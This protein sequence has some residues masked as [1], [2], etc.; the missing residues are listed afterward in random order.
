MGGQWWE[1]FDLTRNSAECSLQASD[2]RD[3]LVWVH[4]LSLIFKEK[5]FKTVNCWAYLARKRH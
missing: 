3:P 1:D 5:I 2:L 4:M